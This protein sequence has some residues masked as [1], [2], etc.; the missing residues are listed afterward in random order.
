MNRLPHIA[1]FFAAALLVA[2]EKKPAKATASSPKQVQQWIQQL[3]D[4]DFKVREEA[5]RDLIK[6]GGIALDAV[7]KAT[8]S[9]DA[10]VRQRALM[11]IK[12]IKQLEKA[13]IAYFEKLG[14][15]ITVDEK[16]S[17]KPVIKISLKGSKVTD[18]GLVHL[19]ELPNLQRLSLN[20]TLGGW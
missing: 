5:T 1:I 3:G 14:G 7:A 4:D 9:K 6:A 12:R 17:G 11:I 10:E 8:K 13:A 2:A 16:S 15:Q 19:K 20:D 18:A